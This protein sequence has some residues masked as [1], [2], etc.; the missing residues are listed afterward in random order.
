MQRQDES[1]ATLE[2]LCSSNDVARLVQ[3]LLQSKQTEDRRR[4]LAVLSRTEDARLLRE[5]MALH[6]LKVLSSILDDSAQD[7]AST[8]LDVL[9]RLPIVSRN[10]VDA[11][12]LLDRLAKIQS[13]DRLAALHSRAS[14]LLERW[15]A[16][17]LAYRIPRQQGDAG[18]ATEESL[19]TPASTLLDTPEEFSARQKRRLVEHAGA[20]H[21]ASSRSLP[22][23][24]EPRRG[25]GPG[26]DADSRREDEQRR[27]PVLPQHWKSAAAP[28]GRVYY[29]HELTS[30][31]QWEF[32]QPE[33]QT[34]HEL[35]EGVTSDDVSAVI[36]RV[37]SK[38]QSQPPS[39][40]A[41]LALD[42]E[43]FK[44]KVGRECHCCRSLNLSSSSCSRTID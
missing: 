6:G 22:K 29:Y 42:R 9:D 8:I 40:T 32:P 4:L 14:E 11:A 23:R 18:E 16:L 33:I 44:E 7:L 10:G 34:R 36:K 15:N 31:T 24:D 1:L 5:F 35:L 41:G 43:Q 17:E 12:G 19:S 37:K 27:E 2:Q 3:A 13:D 21:P 38:L 25:L 28:D 26:R 39:G 30:K 20:R